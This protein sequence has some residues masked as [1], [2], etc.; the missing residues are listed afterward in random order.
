MLLNKDMPGQ[1]F[2]GPLPA[3]TSRQKQLAASLR[4]DVEHLAGKIGERHSGRYQALCQA[5]D[6]IQ[7]S[8]HKAGYKVR[9]QNF[10]HEGKSYTNLECEIAGTGS[11]VVVVGAH[12]DSAQGCP[13]ANDNASGV[14]AL[15]A[16][17]RS[18]KQS[19]AGARTLRFVAFTNEEPPHFLR[20]SMG[21]LVYAKHCQKR[22]DK[23]VAMLS[24]ETMGYYMDQEGSQQVPPPLGAAFPKV[25]NFIAFVANPQS[26]DLLK[27]CVGS[28]RKHASFPSQ[29]G[30]LPSHIPGVGW[31]DHWSFWQIG[32]PAL[33]VTDTAPFRYPY[34]HLA[35][36]TPEK[37][38]YERLARVVQ[39]LEGVLTDLVR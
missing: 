23:I 39:G 26:G 27:K 14:A 12:Y 18:R 3:L 19:P 28:F 33:M 8:L 10:V 20:S 21:S 37:L 13:A 36:D 24:L 5:R 4:A 38:D 17:A 32:V 34:Y 16:L 22:G 29:G 1:T 30:A 31:S 11:G 35:E 9:P 25:G 15:L 2:S 6:W 7:G